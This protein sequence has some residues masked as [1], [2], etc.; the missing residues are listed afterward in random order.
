VAKGSIQEMKDIAKKRG[1]E[2]L[3][4]EYKNTQTKLKWRCSCGYEWEAKPNNIKNGKWCPKCGIR[5]RSEKRKG[6]IEEMKEIAMSQGGECLSIQYINSNT[7]LIWGCQHGHTWEATPSNI[8]RGKWC[9]TCAI[10]KNADSK[11]KTINDMQEMAKIKNGQCLSKEYL[12][13]NSK[14]LWVCQEGHK[15][16][17]TP[18]NIKRGKWCP[19]CVGRNKSLEDMQAIAK[20]HNGKCLST[21]FLMMTKKLKWQCEHGHVW[22]STPNSIINQDS[23]CPI[24]AGNSKKTIKDMKKLADHRGGK[25]LSKKYVNIDTTLLWECSNG[26]KFRLTPYSIGKGSWCPICND[27]TLYFNEEKCRFILES[28]LQKKFFKS[29]KELGNGFELDG[30]NEEIRLAFEYNGVQH[31]TYSPYFHNGSETKFDEQ[32][33]RDHE[34]ERLCKKN[35]INL[36]VIPYYIESDKDKVEYIKEKLM[37]LGFEIINPVV[38]WRYFYK[39]F[40][41]LE[42]L[43]SIASEKGGSCLSYEYK[44]IDAHLSWEC[45]NGHVWDTSPYHI[46][47]G[48][49][50]PKCLGRGRTIEDMRKIAEKKGGECLSEMY[51]NNHTKLIW[52]CKKGHIWNAAP[53]SVTNGAWCPKCS[54]RL[55]TINDMCLIAKKKNGKCLSSQYSN[56]ATKLLWECHNGHQWEAAP[57]SIQQGSWCPMCNIKTISDM[58][59]LAEGYGGKCLSD[60][61]YGTD[62][63]LLWECSHGHQWEATPNYVQRG[64]WCP[65]CKV[66]KAI[67]IKSEKLEELNDIARQKDGKCLSSTYYDVDTKLKWECKYG[68]QWESTPYSIKNGSWCHRCAYKKA[69]Q[70]QK[71]TIEDMQKLAEKNKGRCL[72]N[73]YE[74][75]Q[76]KLLWECRKGHRWYS[77]PNTIQQGSWCPNCKQE[78]VSNKQR[79]TIT[80][81]IEL[82]LK[83]SGECLSKEYVNAHTKLLWRCKDGHKW[84]AKPNNIQQGKWC[85]ICARRKK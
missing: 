33:L 77:K 60:S 50:C 39:G 67:Q 23:W 32:K 80:D 4:N 78:E 52:Q 34:K 30:Y 35:S 22:E 7:H 28:L 36:I 58:R 37:V 84:E 43:Q 53:V 85:P 20:Q 64:R 41:P 2:C 5:S 54:G 14:L 65:E 69:S 9:P 15:W 40:N 71:S 72:S 79:K 6:S 18:S 56:N 27:N 51:V 13:M 29:R 73:I 8:K 38:E 10:I 24:C 44:G 16:E 25:C 21:Q 83:R 76:T 31:Y 70:R 48:S 81:M 47:K 55:L 26:H 19:T 12:N 17:A 1:G 57:R 49:W 63:K 61:Y 75:S 62:T 66:Q 68:H 59:R 74:N 11:R 82:A 45:E 46:K 42:E 3:S